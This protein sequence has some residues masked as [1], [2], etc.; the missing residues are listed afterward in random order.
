MFDTCTGAAVPRG[1]EA[2][3]DESVRRMIDIVG[4]RITP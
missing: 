2:R 1:I 3:I 4:K